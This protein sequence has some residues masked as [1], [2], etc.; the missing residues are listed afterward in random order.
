M[1]K[2]LKKLSLIVVLFNF[3]TGIILSQ[4][5]TVKGKVNDL[6]GNP[7]PGATV[8]VKGST[9]GTITDYDGNFVLSTDIGNELIISYIGF[10]DKEIKVETSEMML[11]TLVEDAKTL[12]EVIVVGYGTQRKV[13]LTGAVGI[14]DTD[15]IK[16]RPVQ[17]AF[18]AL[19]GVSAGLNIN[20]TNGGMLNARPDINIRGFATIGQ[21]SP[22]V[23]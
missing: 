23:H 10:N 1:K 6:S 7:L 3:S 22:V 17:N 5:I 8:Q 14:V 13:N 16:S 2:F 9:T 11:I 4:Q 18:Q 21:G 19:Q 12:D 20:Y 15:A